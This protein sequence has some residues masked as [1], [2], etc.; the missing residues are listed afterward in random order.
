MQ[1][2]VRRTYDKEFKTMIVNLCLSGRVAR[3]VAEE[4]DLDRSMVQRWVREYHIYKGN[5]FPGT[6]LQ[7]QFNFG[8]RTKACQTNRCH[9]II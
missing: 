9:Y 4:M 1:S 5:S 8:I 3:D 6:N 7:E 2:K